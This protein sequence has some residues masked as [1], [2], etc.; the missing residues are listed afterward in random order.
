MAEKSGSALFGFIT[1]ASVPAV[2]GVLQILL[3]PEIVRAT[4]G[5]ALE[6]EVNAYARA[7]RYSLIPVYL[8]VFAGIAAYWLIFAFR[9]RPCEGRAAN[10]MLSLAGVWFAGAMLIFSTVPQPI[11][12]LK[13]SCALFGLSDTTSVYGFDNRSEC[14]A[15][16]FRYGMFPFLGIPIALMIASAAF[17]ILSSGAQP[18][19]ESS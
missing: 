13:P 1:T 10:L 14:E 7:F 19:A 15:V 2:V 18:E 4:V 16:L 9:A 6:I 12:L 17:R 11:Y 8:S 3:A 5:G